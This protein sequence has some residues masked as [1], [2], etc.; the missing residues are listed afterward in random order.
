MSQLDR[1]IARPFS[2]MHINWNRLQSIACANMGFLFKEKA[3]LV[4]RSSYV[5]VF[6][7]QVF[8]CSHMKFQFGQ[9]TQ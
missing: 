4:L 8:M 5:I 1:F 6:L 2:L 3:G 7:G 9:N